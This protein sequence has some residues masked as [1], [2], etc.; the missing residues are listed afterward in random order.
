MMKLICLPVYIYCL[1]IGASDD[2]LREAIWRDAA[3][4]LGHDPDK[5]CSPAE[6]RRVIREASTRRTFRTV[7][8]YRAPTPFLRCVAQLLRVFL[9]GAPAM[10]IYQTKVMG[11]LMIRHGNGTVIVAESIGEDCEVYQQVTVGA[12]RGGFPV[13]GDRVDLCAGALVFG[14]I[15]IGNDVIIGA[16]AVVTKNVPDQAVMVGNPA[17]QVGT[18]NGLR[19]AEIHWTTMAERD[20]RGAK[21]SSEQPSPA[22]AG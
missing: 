7:A 10:E 9:S 15:R 5:S 4:E 3:R 20:R 18:T 19:A 6:Q 8:Y 14:G 2:S 16:G 11:G 13:I 12:G 1:W 21:A 17:R 22:H